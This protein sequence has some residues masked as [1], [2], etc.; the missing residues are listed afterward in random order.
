VLDKERYTTWT[1]HTMSTWQE[2]LEEY[3]EEKIRSTKHE[4]Q[5][6]IK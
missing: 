2:G 1:N 5:N 6:N 3:L 4:T